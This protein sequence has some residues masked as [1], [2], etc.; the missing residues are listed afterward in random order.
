MV[1]RSMLRM[2]PTIT[3]HSITLTWIYLYNW[4]ENVSFMRINLWNLCDFSNPIITL[5]E[6]NSWLVD[7]TLPDDPTDIAL[8]AA[9]QLSIAMILKNTSVGNIQINWQEGCRCRTKS[10]IK[11]LGLMQKTNESTRKM[12]NYQ[13]STMVSARE[14]KDASCATSRSM[15]SSNALRFGKKHR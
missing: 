3:N 10:P 12:F 7:V 2:A 1:N 14:M 13:R 9:S 5:Q 15:R 4:Y 11:A 6:G 8:F